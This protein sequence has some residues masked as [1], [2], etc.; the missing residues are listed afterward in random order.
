MREAK[1]AVAQDD[2]ESALQRQQAAMDS[3]ANALDQTEQTSQ[4]TIGQVTQ[5]IE[6]AQNLANQ[7]SGQQQSLAQDISDRNNS[8]DATNSQL[9]QQ[10][11]VRR[12]TE[13][14]VEQLQALVGQNSR[15]ELEEAIKE[16]IAT[17]KSLTDNKPAEA[18]KSSQNAADRLSEAADLLE[19][20]SLLLEQE[21]VAD[22]LQQLR[23]LIERL[24]QEESTLAD[25]ATA[26]WKKMDDNIKSQ[27]TSGTPLP[28]DVQQQVVQESRQY[29]ARQLAARQL[30]ARFTNEFSK[31]P[32]FRLA[33]DAILA[34][35]DQAVAGFERQ[36]YA[37][38]AIPGTVSA[39]KKLQKLQNAMAEVSGNENE[40]PE[41]NENEEEPSKETQPP[42]RAPLASL[43]L[44]RSM[45]Q[46][47]LEETEALAKLQTSGELPP[48]QQRRLGQLAELQE[49][50][51]KQVETLANEIGQAQQ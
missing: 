43:K 49:R 10:R 3:L 46:D 6:N 32:A 25:D 48:A 26:Y 23:P 16:Q 45:Q 44:L 35:M 18:T 9:D 13:Q 17:E 11:N 21:S 42:S 7:L 8:E 39:L 1:E 41:E 37:E 40:N 12:E 5:A 15:A 28:D 47:L 27:L 14:L 19:E 38:T 34:D 30:L 36:Q 31:L 33:T 22:R 24:V 20:M 29:A 50:L 4:A 2:F 51:A